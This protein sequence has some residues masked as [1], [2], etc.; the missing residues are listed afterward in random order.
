MKKKVI[1]FSIDRL[2]DYLIRSNTIHEISNNFDFSEI[3]ASNKNFKLIHSQS[4]FS[5]VYNFNT[6]NKFVDKIKFINKFFLK[7]Y[8]ATIV[9]DGKNIS[10]ILL[11]F[12]RSKFK[13]TFLYIKKSFLN[14]IYLIILTTLYDLLKIKYEFLFSRNMIENKNYDNYP[15]KYM[16][17]NKYFNINGN[18]VYY[19][20][21]DNISDYDELKNE[22]IIFHLDEKFI[23]IDGI[24]LDFSVALLQL[25]KKINKKIFLTTYKNNFNYYTSL[26]YQKIDFIDLNLDKL[27][28]SD[29][30]IIKE[31]PLNHMYNL[32]QNSSLNISCHSGYFVH[33]SLY[34]KKKTIDIINKNEEIWYNTWIYNKDNYE[35]VNKSTLVKKNNIKDILNSIEKKIFNEFKKK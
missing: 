14:K 6:N 24:N 20:E 21:N 10:N 25:Q 13:F 27:K 12:I 19:Y 33:T 2:G 30:L 29:I 5:K 1:F 7:K 4:F 11:L 26:T 32:M 18:N 17:L 23:D 22:Y 3:V 34:L 9:F 28:K 31:I 15:N 16:S 8:D 35:V